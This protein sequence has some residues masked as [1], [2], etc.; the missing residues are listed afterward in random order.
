MDQPNRPYP[1]DFQTFTFEQVAESCPEME[2]Y[3]NALISSTL[4]PVLGVA[5]RWGFEHGL[6]LHHSLFNAAGTGI[7]FVFFKLTPEPPEPLGF[8][9]E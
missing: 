7:I 8:T 2:S 6:M 5:Y 9:H 3:R 4:G 1:I